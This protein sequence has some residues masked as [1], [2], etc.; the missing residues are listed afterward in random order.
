MSVNKLNHEQ[1]RINTFN[2]N[3]PHTF[4]SPHIL[5]KTGF[6]YIGPYDRVK[7]Y[8][9]K[10]KINNWE[11]GDYEIIEHDRWSFG[12]PLLMQT[13]ATNIPLE[14]TSELDELLSTVSKKLSIDRRV[15]AYPETPFSGTPRMKTEKKK[16]DFPEF[17]NNNFRLKSFEKWTEESKPT[18][19]QMSEAGFFFTGKEDR[20]ICFNCGGGLKD[21][22]KEDDPWEQHALWYYDCSHLRTIKSLRYIETVKQKFNQ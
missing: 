20:V 18:P 1:N 6:Y 22:E 17:E 16:P 3:W 2:S 15:E 4:I 21:W 8:F 11:M 19:Q 7:C 14:Q 12:C 5:A 10:V 9:C 13:S